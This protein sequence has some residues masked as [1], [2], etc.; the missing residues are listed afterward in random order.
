MYYAVERFEDADMQIQKALCE[1]SDSWGSQR[2]RVLRTAITAAQRFWS[3]SLS[4]SGKDAMEA[5]LEKLVDEAA[6]PDP[7]YSLYEPF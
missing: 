7:S 2:M 1:L 4:G 6:L 3:Q 5:W